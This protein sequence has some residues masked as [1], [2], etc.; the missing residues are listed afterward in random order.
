VRLGGTRCLGACAADDLVFAEMNWIGSRTSGD[1][2]TPLEGHGV[3]KTD[4]PA[5]SSDRDQF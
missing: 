3:G 1:E 4:P 2:T 5:K